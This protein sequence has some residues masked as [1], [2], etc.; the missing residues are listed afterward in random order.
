ME[1]NTIIEEQEH[2]II[3]PVEEQSTDSV[4]DVVQDQEQN[5]PTENE[6]LLEYIKKELS[7]SAEE[8]ISESSSEISSENIPEDSSYEIQSADYSNTLS[9]IDSS[10]SA[11]KNELIYQTAISD[12]YADNNNLQS[13]I[14]DISLTNTLLIMTLISILFSA[15]INFSRRI[16]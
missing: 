14:N 6:I 15:L 3:E 12:D 13:D 10:L 2:T 11:I 5:E 1:E 9:S 7:K 8:S 16:F 4:P